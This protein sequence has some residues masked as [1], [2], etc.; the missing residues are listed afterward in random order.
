MQGADRSLRTPM[1]RVKGLGAAHAGTD[2]FWKQRL[3]AIANIPLLL[4]LAF[5]VIALNRQGFAGARAVVAHPFVA[6]L[7]LLTIGS[8]AMHM[9]VGMQVIIED[10]LH[11]E[12]TK[13][14]AL[15]ANTFFVSV[16]ALAG[17]FAVLKIAFG[18]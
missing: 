12:S 16:A 15:I 8:V 1:G 11:K 7:L 14:V 18:G 5:V 13:F 9:K 3:T 17:V 2:H 4:G 6:V 10:Y